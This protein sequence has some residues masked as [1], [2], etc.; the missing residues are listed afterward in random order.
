[1]CATPIVYRYN[2]RVG[3]AHTGLTYRGSWLNTQVGRIFSIPAGD[4]VRVAVSLRVLAARDVGCGRDQLYEE[5]PDKKRRAPAWCDRVLW[6]T[7]DVG[8]VTSVRYARGDLVLSDHKPVCAELSVKVCIRSYD[9]C[10]LTRFFVA[11]RFSSAASRCGCGVAELGFVRNASLGIRYRVDVRVDEEGGCSLQR[12]LGGVA[13]F[14]SASNGITVVDI[15]T[16]QWQ[17]QRRLVGANNRKS[18]PWHIVNCTTA[19]QHTAVL[20]S[21]LALPLPCRYHPIPHS[22]C[23]CRCR[24]SPHPQDPPHRAR[25]AP[26]KFRRHNRPDP[27]GRVAGLRPGDNSRVVRHRPRRCLLQDDGVDGA[28]GGQRRPRVS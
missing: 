28:E 5:R 6:R 15:A 13:I 27:T 25:G 23:R 9:I 10:F 7:R 24:W 21:I 20:I 1:M 26:A 16:D 17:Q 4:G 2:G 18:T 8:H 12:F 19:G 11:K 3:L 14:L 22:L